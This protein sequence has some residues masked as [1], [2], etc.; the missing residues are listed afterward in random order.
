MKIVSQTQ[1]TIE[2]DTIENNISLKIGQLSPKVKAF[3]MEDKKIIR[4]NR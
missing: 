1:S 2:K 3:K 4:K